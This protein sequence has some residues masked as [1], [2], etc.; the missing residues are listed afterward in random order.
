[1]EYRVIRTDELTHH[2]ILGMKWGVRRYQNPDGSL[3]DA[4]KVR[5]AAG[6]TKGIDTR[7]Y[8][9]YDKKVNAN[10][11]G[12]L[13]EEQ[14]K[15][16][17][18]EKRLDLEDEIEKRALE[19]QNNSKLYD[20]Y[21]SEVANER[22][23]LREKAGRT[24]GE[25]REDFVKRWVDDSKGSIDM[26]SNVWEL[27]SGKDPKTK[28]LVDKGEAWYQNVI[29]KEGKNGV[30]YGELVEQVLDDWDERRFGKK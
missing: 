6:N 1:M 12:R 7:A 10:K 19:F 16:Y 24:Q 27:Y 5:Y 28:A 21:A 25:S 22:Y 18:Y 4:G 9:K 29:D 3:T 8:I 13:T 11:Y 30:R 15:K 23:D 2:G 17:D 14:K 20:K 26:S